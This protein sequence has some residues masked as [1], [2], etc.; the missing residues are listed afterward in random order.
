MNVEA[1]FEVLADYACHT[2]EGPIYCEIRNEVYWTDIPGERLFALNLETQKHRQIYSGRP[3][4]G[5]TLQ[6]DGC[7]LLFR[8]KGNIVVWNDGEETTIRE[9]IVQEEDS[10]FNDVL[11]APDGRV[12]CGTMSSS[13]GPGRLYRL[14]VNGELEL[15]LEGI[16]CSNGMGFSPDLSR[17]YYVD[18]TAR[19]VYRFSYNRDSGSISGQ[20]VLIRC[21]EADGWPDGMTVDAVGCLWI[22]FWDGNALRQYS[23]NGE[24]VSE[25]MFPIRKVSCVTFGGPSYD[26][27]FV[28]T[29]GG[30]QKETEGPHAGALLR[31]QTVAKGRP[32][33]RSNVCTIVSE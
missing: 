20:E 32:E 3:V 16:G 9:S 17:F 15:L 5:F 19:E 26:Q 29:A 24:L 10:R 23:P 2:G 18:S 11:A 7:L 25:W 14:D 31:V 4:G 30:H 21:N 6:A 12:F 22:A 8:D 27:L 28:T 13:A 33:F 1:A